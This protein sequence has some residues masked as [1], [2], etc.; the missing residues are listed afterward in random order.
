MNSAFTGSLAK[1]TLNDLL[2]I[3][4]VFKKQNFAEGTKFVVV[5][6]PTMDSYI[7]GDPETKSLLTRFVNSE[8]DELVGYK[9]AKL[10]VRSQVALYNPA[11]GGVV[12]PTGVV[13]AGA[14]SAG[15][16][17]I[18]DQVGL[19]LA[20]LDVFMIQVPASYGYEM[21]ADIRAGASLMR[22]NGN[23]TALYTYGDPQN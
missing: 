20:N 15:L 11:T 6:D 22:K 16:A 10:R 13:P 18:P 4:Q 12:D 14:V 7:T 21:S 8:G 19:G 3:D 17:F 5:Q 23:G 2:V 1:P 9:D